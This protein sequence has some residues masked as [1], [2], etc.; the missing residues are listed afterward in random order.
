MKVENS[1]NNN[2]PK[3]LF[4]H[5]EF[6]RISDEQIA[7]YEG[8]VSKISFQELGITWSV[9]I[10]FLLAYLGC[11]LLGINY[12][13]V[14][15]ARILY[16]VFVFFNVFAA[17]YAFYSWL[18]L[19]TR[20]I[21]SD[22]MLSIS[23]G[24][25]GAAF[26]NSLD[27]FLW[28]GG[29]AGFKESPVINMI[30]VFSMLMAFPGIHMLGRVCRVEFNKQPLIYYLVIICTY[31]AIPLIMNP[32]IIGSF[33]KYGEFSQYGNF[34]NGQNIK[35]FFFGILY[36]MTGGYL[37]SV[38]LHVWQS[39][40]GKLVSSAR[41][42]CLGMV[43][44]SFGCAIYAGLFPKVVATEVASSPINFV[45]AL[46]YVLTACGIR[47]TERILSA[48]LNSG[49]PKLP[50]SMMLMELF[51]KT[52]GLKVYNRL[53]LSIKNT[54]QD[55]SKSREE[56]KLK[57]EEISE[58]ESEI[59]LRKQVEKDLVLAKEKAEEANRAKSKFLAMMS[60]ELKT[61]LTVIKGYSELLKGAAGKK[62]IAQ[63]KIPEI[64]AQI[65]NSS[66]NLAAMVNTLLEFS[67]L[68]SGTFS[69]KN[70]IFPLEKILPYVRAIAETN[71][72]ASK[73]EY[74]ENIPDESIMLNTDKHGLQHIIANLLV[75]AF[76]FCNETSVKLEILKEN[77]VLS[78]SVSDKGIGIDK[79]N[80]ERIFQAFYQVS[81]GTNRKFGGI[82]LGLSIVSRIVDEM[83][84]QITL[85]SKP[86]EGSKFTVSLPIIC[87]GNEK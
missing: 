86:G 24:F 11:Y 48:L 37:A 83:E 63:G 13:T 56:T 76:K 1:S 70:E 30:F 21:A 46:G 10:A 65:V 68:E 72:K 57:K 77:N 84:G 54:L 45:I 5:P 59:R 34:C 36:A 85:E 7:K 50:P 18:I 80:Q 33:M 26:G 29:L 12:G 25:I 69:L 42:V 17:M 14:L 35:E 9:A 22:F 78:V 66:D 73:A 61:P 3:R 58:L 82:G 16:A 52:E 20:S 28:L 31:G 38:C 32:G 6:D 55:L 2:I 43:S 41:L 19:P 62:I 27:Y 79:E 44:L 15:H 67:Q 51:G 8:T 81:L 60:H 71:R 74:I 4:E 87:T 53:E 40:K 47:R 64:S 75:N 23:V 39:A 49:S